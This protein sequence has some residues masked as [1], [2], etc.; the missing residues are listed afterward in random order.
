M[1]YICAKCACR[2]RR[3][4]QSQGRESM[5]AAAHCAITLYLLM[6]ES[7]VCDSFF[8][9]R[10]IYI[11][12]YTFHEWFYLWAS[13]THRAGGSRREL[14]VAARRTNARALAEVVR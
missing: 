14:S 11:Y 2:V 7:K 6:D 5:V 12:I 1:L 4:S 13:A 9:L 8:I 3:S 10:N